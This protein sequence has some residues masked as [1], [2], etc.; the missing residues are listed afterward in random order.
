MPTP[1]HSLDAEL[2]EAA[3][4]QNVTSAIH[5]DI[6][7]SDISAE[8]IGPSVQAEAEVIS[9]DPGVFCGAA[10]VVETL[11]CIDPTITVAW[12]V[13]DG[14]D[15]NPNQRLFTLQGGARQLLSAER[16]VLNFVQVLSGTA[17]RTR[18]YVQLI[19]GTGCRLLDTRKT[20]PGLRMAQKYAVHCGG[21][22]NHRIGLFDAFLLKENHILAAGDIRT[23][24]TRARSHR[25]GLPVEVEV[26]NLEELDQAMAAGA[27]IA[28]IDNFSIDQTRTAVAQ[29]RGKIVLEASGNI[30]MESIRAI[31]ETGVD[32]ISCG[33]LTKRVQP[34]DLSM[35]FVMSR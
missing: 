27:D 33:D 12:S 4:L 9:R 18:A 29:S 20:V 15:V 30:T 8:L 21:G 11:R 22:T 10:W 14:D 25:P 26:E 16:T 32:Y 7:Q 2:L 13:A 1:K 31:A 24:V 17:S 35:R 23:A 19:E 3:I 28:L 34:L 6:G 5:E